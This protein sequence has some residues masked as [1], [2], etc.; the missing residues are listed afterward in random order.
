MSTTAALIDQLPFCL[1]PIMRYQVLCIA[2]G[3]GGWNGDLVK[4]NRMNDE[5]DGE[6]PGTPFLR[7]FFFPASIV[8][9]NSGVVLTLCYGLNLYHFQNIKGHINSFSSQSLWC[10]KIISGEEHRNHKTSVLVKL[11]SWYLQY[12]DNVGWPR[13]AILKGNW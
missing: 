12:S 5:H 13:W 6:H 7:L 3:T 2:S 4:T 11:R 9:G 10:S 8:V 1:A